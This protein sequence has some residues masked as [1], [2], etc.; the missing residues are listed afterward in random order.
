MAGR[1]PSS[2]GEAIPTVEAA[3]PSGND[4]LSVRANPNDFGAQ[5]GDA[6]HNLGMTGENVAEQFAQRAATAYA[7]DDIAHKVVPQTS[8][9][10]ASYRGLKG[11]DAIAGH[12]E[13]VDK[14]MKVRQD[15]LDSA[16]NAATRAIM[17]DFMTHHITQ[18]L[19][20]MNR[21]LVDQESIYREQSHAAFLQ[22]M[23]L[24][25]KNAY[26]NPKLSEQI[27]NA[28]LAA[29]KHKNDQDGGTPE[30]FQ[31]DWNKFKSA[32]VS[33]QIEAAVGN[34]DFHSAQRI[35]QENK[36][37]LSGQEELK[38]SKMLEPELDKGYASQAVSN[39]LAG[40]GM[41]PHYNQAKQEYEPLINKV[42]SETG[43]NPNFLRGTAS[44]ETNFGAN[45]G[46]RGNIGQLNP[47]EYQFNS[48]EDEVRG[49]AM[50][51]AEAQQVAQKT[52]GR[53][54]SFWET[55]LC[56]QQGAAGGKAILENANDPNI[57]AVDVIRKFYKSDKIAES[58]ITGNG[59]NVTM[60]CQQYMDF[61]KD[62]ATFHYQQAAVSQ[63]Q[64]QQAN[65]TLQQTGSPIERFQKISDW[66]ENYGRD[67]IENSGA[68]DAQKQAMHTELDRRISQS[69]KEAKFYEAAIKDKVN[70]YASDHTLTSTS[71]IPAADLQKIS[72]IPDAVK[73]LDKM[74]DYNQKHPKGIADRDASNY[75]NDFIQ[76][77]QGVL[78][79][80]IDNE[81]NLY[82]KDLT[83]QGFA[84]LKQEIDAKSDP[85]NAAIARM[86]SAILKV[87]QNGITGGISDPYDYA[88]QKS[89]QEWTALF[90]DTYNKGIQSGK[91]PIELL[92][93]KSKD[94]IGATLQ[95]PF[96]ANKKLKDLFM[97]TETNRA[98]AEA[99]N[100]PP[101]PPSKRK[102]FGNF[103]RYVGIGNEY[104][105]RHKQ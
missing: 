78:S 4:Y 60:N 91:K 51:V 75:G 22:T 76:S 86:K 88:G 40:V 48:K 98:I 63:P 90:T 101:P 49:M 103:E 11:K 6:I 58:A 64:G 30:M 57:R 66:A 82:G 20:T 92:D 74:I 53:E 83:P 59:G 72:E 34:N 18:T 17:S 12:Q 32:S 65:V 38:Y 70:Q 43:V 15:S 7:Q 29:I 2:P 14:L 73:H 71:D 93:P 62:K 36:G 41:P 24:Q 79:G 19:D 8:D 102:F 69:Q 47:K 35:L 89:L 87:A 28:A 105:Q 68:T 9:I 85:S 96:Y 61:I 54:P 5:V 3:M 46:T 99:E 52:L 104:F 100:P 37:L 25:D 39:M 81:K 50:K 77:Y 1:Y 95:Q 42:A 67:N 21:H 31:A 16:P 27:N 10:E 26:N 23:A 56:Y 33:G 94:Y 97:Q 45:L 44:I 84:L 55:Y 80:D 13:Y